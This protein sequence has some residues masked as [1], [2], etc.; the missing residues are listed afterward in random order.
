MIY[1]NSQ[2]ITKRTKCYNKNKIGQDLQVAKLD[3]VL[4]RNLFIYGFIFLIGIYLCFY[5]IFFFI[6]NYVYIINE[7]YIDNSC[8]HWG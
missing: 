2:V 3:Q 8:I 4:E 1:H 5:H 6:G 7:I